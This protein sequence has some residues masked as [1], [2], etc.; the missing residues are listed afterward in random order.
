M[1]RNLLLMPDDELMPYVV[2]AIHERYSMLSSYRIK[3]LVT[4]L[5]SVFLAGYIFVC[6][7]FL[8]K[9]SALE[10][11]DK[12]AVALIIVSGSLHCV[13]YNT[14]CMLSAEKALLLRL[15][16]QGTLNCR[17]FLNNR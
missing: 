17:A 9:T 1:R 13:F 7:M 6:L 5:V 12:V 10:W 2:S 11:Y 16:R 8:G 15:A 14:A 3:A 4:A